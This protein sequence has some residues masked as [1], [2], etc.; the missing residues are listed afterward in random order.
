MLLAVVLHPPNER[1]V[2]ADQA[3]AIA[4]VRSWRGVSGEGVEVHWTRRQ[5]AS[6]GA[7]DVPE[8]LAIRGADAVARFAG[9]PPRATG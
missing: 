5:W 6:V 2:L 8:R 9:R 7:Q 3:G 4:W 1:A